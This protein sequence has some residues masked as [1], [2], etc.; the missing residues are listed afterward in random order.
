[1]DRDSQT[2]FA[3]GDQSFIQNFHFVKGCGD[4]SQGQLGL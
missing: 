2:V 3:G 4:N 1:M